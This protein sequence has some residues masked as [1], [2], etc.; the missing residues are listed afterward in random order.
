M[1]AIKLRRDKISRKNAETRKRCDTCE[2]VEKERNTLKQDLKGKSFQLYLPAVHF[3]A[4]FPTLLASCSFCGLLNSQGFL[5][6]RG[7]RPFISGTRE[8]K[9][10]QG[11][12]EQRQFLRTGNIE[13]Q[14][15]YIGEQGKMLTSRKHT[16]ILLTPSYPTFI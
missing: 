8:Q 12:G 1:L 11:T 4:T 5:G 7:V 3:V 13:N 15:F 9:S 16:Y 10:K 2:V 14:D 6:N